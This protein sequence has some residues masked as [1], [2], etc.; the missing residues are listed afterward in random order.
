VEGCVAGVHPEK[1]AARAAAIIKE[2]VAQLRW[3]SE[4][5]NK[6]YRKNVC[7]PCGLSTAAFAVSAFAVSLMTMV[8]S[9]AI[10]AIFAVPALGGP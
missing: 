5:L 6:L 4:Q 9:D 1:T 7:I 2:H 8:V 10:I 3:G